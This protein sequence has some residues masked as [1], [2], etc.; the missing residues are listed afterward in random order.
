MQQNQHTAAPRS[1]YMHWQ[2]VGGP[3]QLESSE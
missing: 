2:H 3:G 1:L